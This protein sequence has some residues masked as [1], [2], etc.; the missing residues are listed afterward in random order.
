MSKKYNKSQPKQADNDLP[1]IAK[2][3]YRLSIHLKNE[4]SRDKQI[5]IMF[6]LQH[7]KNRLY[8]IIGDTELGR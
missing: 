4:S 8:Q 6:N 7:L 2:S 5:E 3:I 1:N